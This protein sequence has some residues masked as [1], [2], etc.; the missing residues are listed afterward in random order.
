MRSTLANVIFLLFCVLIVA[1][2]FDK[3]ETSLPRG[4]VLVLDPAGTLVETGAAPEPAEA[5]FKKF[6]RETPKEGETKSQDLINAIRAAA[7]DSKIQALVIDPRDLEGCD[8]TKLMDIGKAIRHFKET[9]KPVLA[10]SMLYTQ[11]QYLLSSY[12]DS[13]TINPM[14][15]L[16]FTGF[17]MYPTFFKGFLDKFRINF[18]I[19]RVGDYKSA[20]EPFIRESMSDLARRSGQEWLDALWQAYLAETA[21]NRGIPAA[22]ILNYVDSID[23]N[24][25][26]VGGNAAQLAMSAKLVDDIKTEDQFEQ[27][28]AGKISVDVED[29]HRIG[30]RDYLR[31]HPVVPTSGKEMVGVIRARGPILPGTHQESMIGSDNMA[32]LFQMAREDASVVAVVLRIDSPGGSAA[33]SEEIHHEISRTQEAGKPVV[34]SMGSVAASGGYWIASGANRIVASPTT[35]TGSIGIFAAFPT[36]EDTAKDLGITSDGVGTT[37]FSDLGNPLRPISPQ[38][39]AA[40]QQI[41]QFGYDTFI[42]RV[43]AGRRLA[44]AEVE[45]SAQGKVFVGQE[46]MKRKLVDQLGDLDDAVATAG[47][48]AGLTTASSKELRRDLS[49]HEKFMQAFLSS[50]QAFFPA[51]SPT[52]TRFLAMLEGHARLLDTF[53]DP[54]HIYARSLEC[55][56]ALFSR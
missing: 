2:V 18:H 54:S 46:A 9:G 51:Q 1:V 50:A 6:G 31:M 8:I 12:A 44:P 13:M 47:S 55:E 52:V 21:K 53:A 7:T 38:T 24:L 28:L 34:I 5:L 25:R 42:K 37:R 29:L 33:A 15:G 22:S 19:F 49:T 40:I 17:G 32:E 4:A 10:H 45:S 20:V 35:L 41:L 30:F 26:N 39:G 23:T 56:A 36:F 48:L 27:L 11:G 43:A 16:L 3:E 14:G